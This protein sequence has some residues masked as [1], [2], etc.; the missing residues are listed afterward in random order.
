MLFRS[1]GLLPL[2]AG[3]LAGAARL[4]RPGGRLVYATC[5]LLPEEN[6]AQVAA[7]LAAHPDFKVVPLGEAAP[8]VSGSGHPEYLALTC[9]RN[10]TDGFF[11]AVLRREG[12]ASAE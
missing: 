6:E 3:I 7:F 9:A 12:G 2:Q 4:V 1:D 11:A 10:E 5:S 8:Q